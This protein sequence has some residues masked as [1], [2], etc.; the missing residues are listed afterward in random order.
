MFNIF[1]SDA[2]KKPTDVKGIREGML[3]FIKDQLQKVEGGEGKNIKGLQ[4]YVACDA[5]EKH[6]YE[7]AVFVGEENAFRD[8]V[9][10]IADDFAINLPPNWALETFFVAELPPETIKMGGLFV[11]LFIKTRENTIIKTATAYIRIL[12]GEAEQTEYT[13][14]S[15]NE[16]VN[17]GRERKAQASDGFFRLNHIAFPDN[18]TNA[19]NKF[20][21]RQHAHIEWNKDAG[22]FMLFADEGGVPPRNKIKIRAVNDAESEKLTFTQ[23]GHKL[24]EG[25]QIILGESAVLEFSYNP[26]QQ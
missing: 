12:N 22:A 7:T 3:R 26:E 6:I 4:I 2:E 23:V 21:S 18:S 17:I 8:E 16:R 20:I 10:R 5:A 11:G 1:G 25:D 24:K 13:L 15:G 9:Q 14:Q 19:C